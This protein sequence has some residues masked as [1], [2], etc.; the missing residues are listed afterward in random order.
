M[1]NGYCVAGDDWA[2]VIDAMLGVRRL[3]FASDDEQALIAF[4]AIR[5]VMQRYG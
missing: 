2:V 4:T 3:G 5:L 1:S